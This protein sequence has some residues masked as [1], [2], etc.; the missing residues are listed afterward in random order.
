MVDPVR[1]DPFQRIIEVGWSGGG[2]GVLEVDMPEGVSLTFS[3]YS[4]TGIGPFSDG[5]T[6][7]RADLVAEVNGITPIASSVLSNL[8]DEPEELWVIDSVIFPIG[9]DATF[10]PGAYAAY[11]AGYVLPDY[12]FEEPSDLRTLGA[13]VRPG[14]A[15]TGYPTDGDWADWDYGTYSPGGEPGYLPPPGPPSEPNWGL[16]EQKTIIDHKR[17]LVRAIYVFDFAKDRIGNASVTI[18]NA[19]HDHD[20]RLGSYDMTFALRTFRSSVVLT[21][22]G[23]HLTA[24]VESLTEQTRTAAYDQAGT[25]LTV[26]KAGFV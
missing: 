25:L 1:L 7:L 17:D 3:P 10:G 24:G 16:G 13:D 2:L 26:K 18:A 6:L 21:L 14:G 5:A 20:D 11:K 9:F 4:S 19:A 8:Y 22:D 15:L 23:L 12:R